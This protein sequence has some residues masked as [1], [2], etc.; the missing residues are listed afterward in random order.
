MRITTPSTEYG[1]C[2]NEGGGGGDGPISTVFLIPATNV[3][4]ARQTVELSFTRPLDGL[5]SYQL[6]AYPITPQ[7][8]VLGQS[9]LTNPA[10]S[11]PY[12]LYALDTEPNQL[13]TVQIEENSV[14]GDFLWVAAYPPLLGKLVTLSEERQL[15]P[16]TLDFASRERNP[17]GITQLILYYLGGNSFRVL[18]KATGSYALLPTPLQVQSLDEHTEFTVTVSYQVPVQI[19]RLDTNS[20]DIAE[21]NIQVTDGTGAQVA[22]YPEDKVRSDYLSLGTSSMYGPFPLSGTIECAVE[23]DSDLVVVVHIPLEFTRSQATVK[24]EWERK[25]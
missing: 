13:F 20:G 25:E 21:I 4:D 7:N 11:Q 10:T 24:V 8:L 15:F 9:I 2:Y 5:A 1:E 14:E 22:V 18:V 3:P 12:Q 16:Q 6:T 19:I 23:T 17:H